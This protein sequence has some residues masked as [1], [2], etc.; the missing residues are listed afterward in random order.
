MAV[1]D[2]Q[3]VITG[4]GVAAVQYPKFES[5]NI[6]LNNRKNATSGSYDGFK[7]AKYAPHCLTDL[8]YR[9]NRRYDLRAILGHV[10]GDTAR[11][12]P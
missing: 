5:V 10:N 12:K 1:A 2:H 6:S 3:A 9:F 4:S 8:Q 11:T 7:F